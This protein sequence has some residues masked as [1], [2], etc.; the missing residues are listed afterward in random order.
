MRGTVKK[1]TL[2]IIWMKYDS[3]HTKASSSF[4]FLHPD[5]RA[6]IIKISEYW[7][8][9]DCSAK[10]KHVT[11]VHRICHRQSI[12]FPW[13]ISDI[14]QTEHTTTIVIGTVCSSLVGNTWIMYWRAV[15]LSLNCFSPV[16]L[17]SYSEPGSNIYKQFIF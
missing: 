2:Y 1:N 4:P 13:N 9:F 15:L 11:W 17:G 7:N 12:T 3:T 8:I 14:Y 10:I 16:G 6:A 5:G